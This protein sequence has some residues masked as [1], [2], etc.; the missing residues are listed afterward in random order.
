MNRSTSG[1][2]VHHRVPESTQTHVHWIGDAIQPS[3]PLSSPS[4]PAPNPSQHQGLF[5]WVRSS[6]EVAKVLEFQLKHQSFQW[7]P[8]TK[9]MHRGKKKKKPCSHTLESI[10]VS[11]FIGSSWSLEAPFSWYF[12]YPARSEI[13]IFCVQMLSAK[14]ARSCPRRKQLALTVGLTAESREKSGSIHNSPDV[15]PKISLPLQAD[16]LAA[17]VGCCIS[18]RATRILTKRCFLTQLRDCCLHEGR[19][20]LNT[21]SKLWDCLTI[22]QLQCE[23][24]L[25][26]CW[27][28][29]IC[30][31]ERIWMAIK[32][33]PDLKTNDTR[34]WW[35]KLQV[36]GAHM[37]RGPSS[38]EQEEA[39]VRGN[40]PYWWRS[41]WTQALAVLG[42]WSSVHLRYQAG[43]NSVLCKVLGHLET[44]EHDLIW[45]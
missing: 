3:H 15:P 17:L 5:K 14:P 4:P 1:L 2:P 40:C 28:I 25:C 38:A 13:G 23:L 24:E 16:G 22:E 43:L 33:T 9:I 35:S 21:R 8:R 6:H 27:F 12:C 18:H 19:P 30:M 29:R 45:K 37:W 34:E 44:L 11:T 39:T 42:H 26:C 41:R 10:P 31:L 20:Y 7:T 32:I 36:R